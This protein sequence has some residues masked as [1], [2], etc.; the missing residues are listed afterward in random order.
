MTWLDN[1]IKNLEETRSEFKEEINKIKKINPEICNE[2]QEATPL[3]L[4]F[5]LYSLNIY[6]SI[7]YNHIR[8]KKYFDNMFYAD[9]F[10]GS[11]LNMLKSKKDLL[12]GSPFIATLNHKDKF[13]KFFFCEGKVEY[14][15]ALD[16]RLKCL[17]TNSYDIYPKDCNKVVDNIL[18]EIKKF[19]RPHSFFF[20]DPYAME[21]EWKSMKKVLEN[22]CD[23]LFTFMTNNVVRAR[24]SAFSLPNNKT[25][26]LDKFYGN[27]LWKDRLKS[28]IEIYIENICKARPKAI[29][30]TVRIGS[31]YDL[32]FVTKRTKSENKWM[33]GIVQAKKEIE[34]NSTLDKLKRG[35]S[36]LSEF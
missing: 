2:F 24:K 32:I 22:P 4:I 33:R 25:D 11:G 30:E 19:S 6:S 9:L 7:I 20:I 31:Y 8:Q 12:I 28:E 17:N 35:Q 36:D 23:I 13:T 3:K 14:N 18:T 34:A 21:F 10:S 16:S 27:K 29:I 1:Q 5:L 15:K 26:I